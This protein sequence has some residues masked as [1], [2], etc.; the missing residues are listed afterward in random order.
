MKKLESLEK[1][2]QVPDTN[3]YGVYFYDGED[4]ELH[5]E[6]EEIENKSLTIIDTIENGVFH[7]HKELKDKETGLVEITDTTYPIEKGKGLVF[8]Q[9]RGFIGLGEGLIPLDNAIER[10]KLLDEKYWEE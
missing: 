7:K 1:Y 5:N 9:N 10:M 6:T 3:F 2:V 8:I 4:I